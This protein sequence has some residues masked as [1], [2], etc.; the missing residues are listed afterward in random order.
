MDAGPSRP[1]SRVQDTEGRADGLQ[2]Q[3]NGEN[4]M[5]GLNM[6][7]FP[8]FEIDPFQLLIL[9]ILAIPIALIDGILSLFGGSLF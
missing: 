6:F 8:S 4:D 5:W 9:T 2:D 3:P 7:T 1:W